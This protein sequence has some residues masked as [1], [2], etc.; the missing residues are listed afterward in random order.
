MNAIVQIVLALIVAG[1]LFWMAYCL[2]NNFSIKLQ[3]SENLRRPFRSF[4]LA[5]LEEMRA[6]E[7]S[8]KKGKMKHDEIINKAN[9][10]T[11]AVRQSMRLRVVHLLLCHLGLAGLI[12]AG[13]AGL[14]WLERLKPFESDAHVLTIRMNPRTTAFPLSTN[15]LVISNCHLI[16]ANGVWTIRKP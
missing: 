15:T 16:R 11:D 1:S 6:A 9:S 7:E 4:S 5:K 13:D 10:H 2:F 12:L 8:A 3:M 14:K